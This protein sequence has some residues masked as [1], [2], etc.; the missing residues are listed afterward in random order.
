MQQQPMATMQ[1]Q[2]Q[3]ALLQQQ[4]QQQQY[5][6]AFAGTHGTPFAAQAQAGGPSPYSQPGLQ[7]TFSTQTASYA[8]HAGSNVPVQQI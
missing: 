3:S 6:Q 8:G 4:Q 1:Q 7:Q 2:Q 5:Q